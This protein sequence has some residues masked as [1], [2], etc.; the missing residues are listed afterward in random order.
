VGAQ[1][2]PLYEP[3]SINAKI[4]LDW[5]TDTDPKFFLMATKRVG[6]AG[7]EYGLDYGDEFRLEGN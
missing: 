2:G 5:S 1:S 7:G 6:D 3:A 4:V